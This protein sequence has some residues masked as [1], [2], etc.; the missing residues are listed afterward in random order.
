MSLPYSKDIGI[1]NL[2]ELEKNGAYG[3]Y[4][5]IEAIDYTPNRVSKMDSGE[6]SNDSKDVRCYM[7]VITSNSQL[8]KVCL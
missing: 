7:V 1:S 3:R 4:G 5:F 6:D 8:G 2:R